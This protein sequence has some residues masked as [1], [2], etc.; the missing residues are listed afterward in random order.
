MYTFSLTQ[1]NALNILF[2]NTP[3][4]CYQTATGKSIALPSGG[5]SPYTFVWS[6]GSLVDSIQSVFS[7]NYSLTITDS[8]GCMATKNTLI[9]QAKEIQIE[10]DSIAPFC[11]NGNNGQLIAHVNDAVSPWTYVWNTL[12]AQ[13]DSIA[14]G[15]V[16]GNYSLTV[17][18]ANFCIRTATG[19]VP[20]NTQGLKAIILEK[21]N[22]T[23]A[24]RSDGSIRAKGID[25]KPPYAYA[26]S[27]G[28]MDSFLINAAPTV[29]YSLTI[30]D[31][32]ACSDS[33]SAT[34]Q[35]P[36]KF[37]I[38][39]LFKADVSCPGL[40]DGNIKALAK[41]GTADNSGLFQWSLDSINF[42]TNRIFS[43]LKAGK[44]ILYAKDKNQCT[45]S[46]AFEIKEPEALNIIIQPKDTTVLLGEM[47][48]L[49]VELYTAS[50]ILPPNLRYQWTPTDGLSCTKCLEPLVGIY[51]SETFTLE[52]KYL[53]Q[54]IAKEYTKINI[55]N[56]Y[57]VFIPNAF[58]PMEMG[59][60]IHGWSMAKALNPFLCSSSI[61]GEKKSLNPINRARAGMDITM[62][63]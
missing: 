52:V 3:A 4:R 17:T 32:N 61:G 5:I 49:K 23:C 57:Q 43:P 18:D 56:P 37:E 20:A 59:S 44:Y 8:N 27:N 50:G 62:G 12:P 29:L 1:P 51:R 34:I 19:R 53:E 24:N 31:M 13:T 63:K 47:V 26:W 22:T 46:R 11:K 58:T 2:N 9:A 7:G 6:N 60:M 42:Q 54:C 39:T 16:A 33:I 10:F 38:D 41:G 30:T 28:S 25:G 55:D 21:N 15:L 35:S 45:T 36:L 14:N 40:A 48:Q